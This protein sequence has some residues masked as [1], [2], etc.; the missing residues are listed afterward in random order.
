MLHLTQKVITHK[1][2]LNVKGQKVLSSDWENPEVE[3]VDKDAVIMN[4]DSNRVNLKM[5]I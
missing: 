4:V 1:A 3:I 2:N 5:Q